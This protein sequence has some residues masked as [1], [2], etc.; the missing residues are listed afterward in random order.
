MLRSGRQKLETPIVPVKKPPVKRQ[1]LDTGDIEEFAQ[2]FND[3]VRQK[4]I[5]YDDAHLQ[6]NKQVK[7]SRARNIHLRDVWL[8]KNRFFF[9]L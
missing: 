6:Q 9:S 2:D 3:A 5:R 8:F 7:A 1:S 4:R